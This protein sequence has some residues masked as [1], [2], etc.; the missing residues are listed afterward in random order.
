MSEPSNPDSE[1][2]PRIRHIKYK[3]TACGQPTRREALTA[4][5]VVFAPV[6]SPSE[7]PGRR[8]RTVGW[9]CPQCLE[10]DPAWNQPKR[11]A[12]PGMLG[13]SLAEGTDE[14]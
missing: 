5:R 4:K 2:D 6:S 14:P 3:C 1:L 8:T 12:A 7:A 13:T 11:S 9:L 10:H